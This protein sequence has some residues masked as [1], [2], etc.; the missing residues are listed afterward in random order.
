[1]LPSPSCQATAR[2]FAVCGPKMPRQPTTMAA[3]IRALMVKVPTGCIIDS[4]LGTKG[5]AGAAPCP[6]GG[7]PESLWLRDQRP[8]RP[9]TSELHLG[10]DLRREGTVVC[11]KALE[12]GETI[13][14]MVSRPESASVRTS[15]L[16]AR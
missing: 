2:I 10:R 5:A 7:P 13:G 14:P 3:K 1:M 9:T 6:M 4:S 8:A 15:E 11:N 12:A 16:R